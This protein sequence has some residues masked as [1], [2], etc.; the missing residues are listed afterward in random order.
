M[1]GCIVLQNQYA[2]F[3]HA[4]A[5]ELKKKHGVSKF[6]AYIF[7]PG[8]KEFI[9]SQDDIKY[10]PVLV[11]HEL[12]ENYKKEDIDL[13]YI[14]R[15]E[16]E[17]SEPHLW[18]YLYTDR[19]LMMSIGPKEETTAE[20]DPMHDHET[21]LLI[22]QVRA[23]SIEKMLKESK[24]DFIIFF[25][26]GTLG[27]LIIYHVAKKLGI[28]TYNVDYPRIG[29]QVCISENYNTLTGVIKKFE[30]LKNEGD[31]KLKEEAIE[32]IDNYKKTGSLQLEYHELNKKIQPK[33]HNLFKI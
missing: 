31:S 5:L 3:G 1:K 2:K 21:L 25:A 23:K 9:Q 29:S 28:K 32:F 20:I 15:F 17:Y 26:I 10:D 13:E 12:H 18:S 4:I 8:A 27:H 33:L 19:K 11:D 6:C 7:S 16:D 24:P 30:Q 22:F 14:R